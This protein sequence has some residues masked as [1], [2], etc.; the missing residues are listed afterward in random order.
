[1]LGLVRFVRFCSV[2]SCLPVIFAGVVLPDDLLIAD[3]NW[4]SRFSLSCISFA[5]SG[6]LDVPLGVTVS[7]QRCP[8]QEAA[9]IPERIPRQVQLLVGGILSRDEFPGSGGIS[10]AFFCSDSM[11][12]S[13]CKVGGRHNA[14]NQ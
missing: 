14:L 2:Y 13:A 8:H 1:M 7:F 12:C 5:R 9:F 11:N 4:N 3:D 10:P 6:N